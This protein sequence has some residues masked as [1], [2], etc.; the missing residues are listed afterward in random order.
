MDLVSLN[1][2][3]LL[4]KS[5][6]IQIVQYLH[7]ASADD[8]ITAV[9]ADI[10]HI[11]SRL[12]SKAKFPKRFSNMF[13]IRGENN[14]QNISNVAQPMEHPSFPSDSAV[15]STTGCKIFLLYIY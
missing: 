9:F 7:D 13:H 15:A 1:S 4:M 10:N 3:P 12:V 6:T 2:T 5:A 14:M 11:E 8:L